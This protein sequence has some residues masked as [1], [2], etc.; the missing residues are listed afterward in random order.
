M[1]R[2][3]WRRKDWRTLESE[4]RRFFIKQ[5]GRKRTLLFE[6]DDSPRSYHLVSY[7]FGLREAKKLAEAQP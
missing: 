4:P 6:Y 2:Y 3:T 7:C 1:S 5:R